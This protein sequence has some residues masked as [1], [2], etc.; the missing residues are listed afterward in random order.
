MATD[1]NSPTH[2]VLLEGLPTW[3][4]AVAIVGFPIL[5]A[6]FYMAKDSNLLPSVERANAETL[7]EV[8]RQH[9][10]YSGQSAEMV[11]LLREVCHNTAKTAEAVRACNFGPVSSRGD[12]LLPSRGTPLEDM[13]VMHTYLSRTLDD[14][15]TP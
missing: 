15:G 10:V 8:V 5:V 12:N 9:Q 3:V 6:T 13:A 14:P 1:S 2:R 7:A 4:Q 11:R